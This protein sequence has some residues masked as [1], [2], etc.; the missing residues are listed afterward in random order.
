MKVFYLN[1]IEFIV[2]SDQI[3]GFIICKYNCS[4]VKI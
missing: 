4:L 1:S 2:I 3:N